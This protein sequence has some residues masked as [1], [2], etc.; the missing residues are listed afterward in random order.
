LF[1]VSDVW[2]SSQAVHS[3]RQVHLNTRTM[4]AVQAGGAA[5]ASP[6]KKVK[7]KAVQAG[8]EEASPTARKK[9]KKKAVQAIEDSG[10]DDGGDAKE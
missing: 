4:L 7:K 6:R 1:A 10:W 5:A 9:K 3:C 8:G 2:N